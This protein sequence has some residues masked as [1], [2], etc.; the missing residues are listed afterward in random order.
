MISGLQR[1]DSGLRMAVLAVICLII[2]TGPASAIGINR[3]FSEDDLFGDSSFSEWFL[4]VLIIWLFAIPLVVA[5][6]KWDTDPQASVMGLGIFLVAMVML[7]V[8]FRSLGAAL[9]SVALVGPFLL[10]NDELNWDES[11]VYV[12]WA[13]AF[14]ACIVIPVLGIWFKMPRQRDWDKLSF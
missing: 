2:Y 1:F 5:F 7:W 4:W 8:V 13:L 10:W 11:I 14:I 12:C 6:R 3:I 9:L